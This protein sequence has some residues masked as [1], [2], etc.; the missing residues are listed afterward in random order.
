MRFYTNVFVLGNDVHVRGYDGGKRFQLKAPFHPYLFT[1]SP[2]QSEYKTI[3]GKIVKKISFEDIKSAKSF[4]ENYQGVEGFNIYGSALY[5]YQAIYDLYKGEINYDVDKISVVSLDIETSTHNGFPNLELADK[6]VITLSIRKNGKA[7]VLGMKPYKPKSEDVTYWQC[8]NEVDLLEKFLQ[9][10][11]S[12]KWQP[13]VVTGWNIDNF[14]IPYL[15]RRITNL[16]GKKS[17]DRMSPW[18]IVREKAINADGTFKVYDLNGISVLD[19]LALYKK[20]SYTPQESYKLDHIAEYELNEKKLD[21][22]EYETMHEFY[23]QNFEK[24]VDYNIHDVVLVDKLEEKLKFIEQVFAI[25]YDAKVNYIDTFTTVR[26][27]DVIISNYL[28]DRGV[29]VPLISREELD[30]RSEVDRRLGPIIGA[31]VKDPQVGMHN[32]VCSFDLNSLYPHLIMQYNISPDTYVGMEDDMSIERLLD[33]MMGDELRQKLLSTNT[34]MTPNGA[35]FTKNKVG[36]LPTLMET[37]YNDRSMW[38][39]R[40]IDAK[41]KYEET[42][43]RELENEIAR[44]NN[45]QMAKKIQLNSAYGAL[46]NVYFRWYQR[47]LAEAITMSGQLSIRWMEKRINEYLNKTLK[48]TKEDYVIACDTDSM[49]IRLERLVNMFFE[50]DMSNSEK[51]VTFLDNV[52]EKE[53]QPLIDKNYNALAEYMMAMNQKMIMKREAIAN[54]GIW[55]GKKHYILNVYNNEGVQYTQPKLK[56]QGIEAVRSSTPTICRKNFKKALEVIMNYD[57]ASMIN[58]IRDFKQE[59]MSLSFED[60][61]FPRSVKDLGKYRDSSRIY[62]KATPIHVKGSLIYNSLLK[63]KSLLNKYQSIRDGDKIK[64]TYL[65][66]PNPAR[67]TVISC[68]GQLPKEFNIEPY[69]DYDTQFEKS[70]LE[71]IKSILDA[72]GWRVEEHQQNATMERFFA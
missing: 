38:K 28:L 10:W 24:F 2:N 30:H 57:E 52:C 50:S 5:T 15:Y 6:E 41:K 69:I 12:E 20:F 36:F 59:Y 8:K 16:L 46:G 72:I 9:I 56:M 44:C 22:S 4:I 39:K 63:E 1:S 51:I 14:D 55:T 3:D 25:A 23:V 53:L 68:V 43:T 35:M 64:F 71:P 66:T 17:A 40:M 21:Y 18:N 13:D 34:N 45:M 26:M 11:N 7:I 60:I 32:W 48:T 37:M 54:K 29:V 67:D 65:R 47:N 33:N 61:A 49:Y 62:K 19:Y 42:P 70:F 58:F 27:W 31:Y